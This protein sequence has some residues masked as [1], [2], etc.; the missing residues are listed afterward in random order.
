MDRKK[1]ESELH[2]G[3]ISQYSNGAY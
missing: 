2:M 3:L 1:L